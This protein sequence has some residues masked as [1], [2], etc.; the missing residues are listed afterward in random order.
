MLSTPFIDRFKRFSL[1]NWTRSSLIVFALISI[2]S[3]ACTNIGGL[4]RSPS[5][6][7]TYTDPNE[8]TNLGAFRLITVLPTQSSAGTLYDMVGEN[9][10]FDTYCSGTLGVCKCEYT[11]DYSGGS[12]ATYGNVTY[13]ESNL[14]R[15]QNTVPSGV[16]TFTVKVIVEDASTASTG[17][18]VAGYTSNAISVNLSSGTFAGSDSYVDLSNAQSYVQVNRFQCRRRSF[19]PNPL[20]P[21]MI[22]PI[23]SEDPKIIYPFNFFTTNASE[24]ILQ[25]QRLSSQDWECSLIATQD[26]SLHWWA[27]P[28]VYSASTCTS[29]FCAGDSELMYPTAT[30][31]SGKVPV[32]NAAMTGKRRASFSVASRPYGVFQMQIK[33]AVAPN[34][35]VS[36]K[37][38]IIGYGAKPIPNVSGSSSCPSIPLPP[39]A[40]WVKLWNFRATDITPPA[41]VTGSSA[42]T[43]TAIACNPKT[44][45]GVFPSCDARSTNGGSVFGTG[46]DSVGNIPAF[47]S[48]S[49]R[50]AVLTANAGNANACYN[51]HKLNP[52]NWQPTA[53]YPGGA[54]YWTPSP[55][56][57]DGAVAA[58]AAV[59][60]PWEIYDNVVNACTGG[61]SVIRYTANSCSGGGTSGDPSPAL[62]SR[63]ANDSTVTTALLADDPTDPL[64]F[65]DQ[66][67]TI[68]EPDVDDSLMRNQSLAVSHHK[69]V[70]Y[71]SRGDC[72][73]NSRTNCPVNKEIHWDINVKEVGSP[74]SADIYPLCVLQ[75]Y[76]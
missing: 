1:R 29:S 53:T 25:T 68:T 34:N 65:T 35:F 73:T 43:M 19:I 44:S 39:K 48:L 33:A 9:G 17:T 41:Y 31:N 11:Y 30:L 76:D 60:L 16:G 50:V 6:Q 10:E 37:Y 56:G 38:A 49:S 54:E 18:S 7:I 8:G 75:F 26:R 67:F 5:S 13:Q 14:L 71:R 51:I 28:Y 55:F 63:I 47:G 2:F 64:N 24:G 52:L 32:S 46:L 42:M 66:L 57:F 45:S 27:N 58:S 4:S 40:T 3:S 62:A 23:Q 21:T 74:T 59:G 70:T 15:C 20:D 72:N 22:D 12:Q 61:D 36:G 69:P